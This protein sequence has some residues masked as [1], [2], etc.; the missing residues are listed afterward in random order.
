MTIHPVLLRIYRDDGPHTL[1]ATILLTASGYGR[2]H[3]LDVSS[4]RV[5]RGG[6]LDGERHALAA[7]LLAARVR[8]ARRAAVHHA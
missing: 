2:L 6:L 5:W 3:L 1:L 4:E 8:S 7:A